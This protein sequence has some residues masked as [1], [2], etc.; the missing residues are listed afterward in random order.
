M[1]ARQMDALAAARLGE[2]ALVIV[3]GKSRAISLALA[4]FALEGVPNSGWRAS[5]P[6]GNLSR[7]KSVSRAAS[8][9]RAGKS[10][11]LFS[12]SEGAGEALVSLARS[13]D[14]GAF[15]ARKTRAVISFRAVS[16]EFGDHFLV[17]VASLE[18]PRGIPPEALDDPRA[19]ESLFSRETNVLSEVARTVSRLP[20][21]PRAGEGGAATTA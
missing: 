7:R 10:A 19:A 17:E 6:P 2:G 12:R 18:N 1:T 8:S 4:A 11:A 14:D 13:G 21:K 15:L 5:K 3:C 9:L 16:D 20:R